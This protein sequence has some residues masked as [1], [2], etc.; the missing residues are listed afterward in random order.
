MKYSIKRQFAI[1]FI[2]LMTATILLCWFVNNTFLGKYYLNN[3]MNALKNAYTVINKAASAGNILTEEFGIQIQKI[4]EKYNISLVVLDADSQTRIT[5]SSDP[6]TMSRRLWDNFFYSSNGNTGSTILEENSLYSIQRMTDSRTMTEYVEMWGVL[7]NGNIFLLRSALEGI[8]DSVSIANRF[9]AYVGIGAAV[10]SGFVILMVSRKV[11]EPILELADISERMI[12]L[13]FDAKYT[14][15][16]KTEIAL[17]GNNINELSNALETTISELKTANNELQK[18]IEK[19]NEIDE[20]RKDFLS[21]VSHELK[22]PIALIQG[23][24]EGLKEGINDD[25]ESREFYCDVIIDEAGKMNTMVKKLLTLNQLEFGND[26]VSMERF[27]IA[28]LIRNYIQSAEI[29]TRQKE[30]SV[31]FNVTEAFFV[32]GDEFKTEEVFA[33]YFS[34]AMNHVSGAKIIDI[35]LKRMKDKVRVSVFNTGEQ[36]PQESLPHLWE[37]FYKVDKART[38]AYGGSGVGLS[39]VKAIMESMNQECGVMNYDNGVEF[40]FELASQ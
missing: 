20:M 3:K 6:D 2:G 19:K 40:W 12:H 14:G 36:I 4:A 28:A 16:S 10:V 37:K 25:A 11:T 9:L 8:Q 7:D 21:N 32:W 18:D 1:I 22:T 30:I 29:L 24:A 39:I 13:D 5:F 23:Y 33:N 34:N 17:L 31:F 26:V 27:D 38:R 15:K 35:R